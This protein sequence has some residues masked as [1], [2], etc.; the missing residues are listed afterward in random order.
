MT[1]AAQRASGGPA[2]KAVPEGH[3]RLLI[4]GREVDAPKGE[5]VIRTCERLG[6]DIGGCNRPIRTIEANASRDPECQHRAGER[7]RGE[8]PVT[9]RRQH[10][11]PTPCP[12]PTTLSNER[13]YGSRSRRDPTRAE[14]V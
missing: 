6:N 2:P 5:L 13:I 10:H 9:P 1:V 11:P 14:R 8:Y 12:I 3:V 4:D 7:L